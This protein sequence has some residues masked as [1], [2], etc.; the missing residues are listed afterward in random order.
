MVMLSAHLKCS[1]LTLHKTRHI[2]TNVDITQ[3]PLIFASTKYLMQRHASQE[4]DY[5]STNIV[6]SCKWPS[7]V[8]ISVATDQQTQLLFL[9]QV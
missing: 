4:L 1:K 8:D 6:P 3:I 5:T 2:D 7:F 9:L